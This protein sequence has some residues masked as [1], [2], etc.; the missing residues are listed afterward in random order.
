MWWNGLLDG[1]P[2]LHDCFSNL[3]IS[4]AEQVN[5]CLNR[6]PCLYMYITSTN[7]QRVTA[8]KKITDLK[9]SVKNNQ[10]TSEDW[11]DQRVLSPLI[12]KWR[13]EVKMLSMGVLKKHAGWV[14]MV[15]NSRKVQVKAFT[16]ETGKKTIK[17][18][19]LW[20]CGLVLKVMNWWMEWSLRASERFKFNY[21]SVKW[22]PVQRLV[23]W[24]NKSPEYLQ[25]TPPIVISVK[26]IWIMKRSFSFKCSIN[27]YFVV[28]RWLQT[29]QR[30]TGFYFILLIATA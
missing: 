19:E 11:E 26:K 29:I 12:T 7:T 15:E 17:S 27:G 25:C 2:A 4:S 22:K 21:R 5:G 6:R 30:T 20:E 3:G 1:R 14:E 18:K 8:L 23:E 28:L 16:R 10:R 13:S 24:A 9:V